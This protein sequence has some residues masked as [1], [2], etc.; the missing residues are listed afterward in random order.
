MV[1]SCVRVYVSV[2]VCDTALMTDLILGEWVG[3]SK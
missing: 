2:G 1:M 3:R